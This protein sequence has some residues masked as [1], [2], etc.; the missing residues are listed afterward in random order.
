MRFTTAYPV[1]EPWLLVKRGA[2]LSKVHGLTI[3]FLED[4]KVTV[5]R[6]DLGHTATPEALAALSRKKR[7]AAI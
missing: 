1:G 3:R 5:F 7:K 2:S 4:I 6:A